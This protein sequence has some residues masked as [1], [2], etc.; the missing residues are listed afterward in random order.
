MENSR[1]AP[2]VKNIGMNLYMP[3]TF[4][5]GNASNARRKNAD[6]LLLGFTTFILKNTCKGH[7]DNNNCMINNLE[8]NKYFLWRETHTCEW[9]LRS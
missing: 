8:I 4:F 7:S 1:A 3:K 5:P 2:S 6:R 9:E